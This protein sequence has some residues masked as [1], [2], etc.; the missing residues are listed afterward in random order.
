MKLILFINF[1]LITILKLKFCITCKIL[2]VLSVY[3]LAKVTN[4]LVSCKLLMHMFLVIP[5]VNVLLLDE[6]SIDTPS[7]KHNPSK[8]GLDSCPTSLISSL[9]MSSDLL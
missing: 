7:Y 2:F 3:K 4:F 8:L 9:F 1:H 5:H 6:Y